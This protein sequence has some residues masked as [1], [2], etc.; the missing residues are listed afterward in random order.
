MCGGGD[1]RFLA[2]LLRV[3]LHVEVDFV[4]LS[5]KMVELAER[6]VAG[7]GETFR[8]RVRFRVR[9]VREFEP[10]TDG[11]DLIV[12]H[13]FLDCFSEPE[14]AAIVACLGSWAVPGARWIVSDFREAAGPVGR[15]WTRAVIRGLYA[16]FRLTTGLLVTRTQLRRRS[17]EK[18]ISSV[19]KRKLWVVSCIPRSGGEAFAAGCEW[20]GTQL[21]L[22]ADNH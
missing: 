7:M 13:F 10:R 1:G 2:R 14:L 9:D 5:P 21:V 18:G 11:Y 3:N 4:D 19:V 16:A 6:R 12:T 17:E 8:K 15:L 20:N 22:L